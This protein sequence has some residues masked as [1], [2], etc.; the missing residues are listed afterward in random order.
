MVPSLQESSR[1]MQN[2]G[3]FACLH[4]RNDSAQLRGGASRNSIMFT[5]LSDSGPM[6]AAR[7]FV[8]SR[9]LRDQV[10]TKSVVRVRCWTLLTGRAC[11]GGSERS[12]AL[13]DAKVT[14]EHARQQV[15]SQA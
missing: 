8:Q 15:P 3:A 10:R 9:H 12:A 11:T 13:R 4:C 1:V 7:R 2:L 14:M 6:E 5:C